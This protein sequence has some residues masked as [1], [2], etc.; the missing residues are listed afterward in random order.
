MKPDIQTPGIKMNQVSFG[1]SSG[2]EQNLGQSNPEAY[3][4]INIERGN[5][6]TEPGNLTNSV[7]PA[8]SLPTPA[9]AD[10]IAVAQAALRDIPIIANDDDLIEKEWVERAKRIVS[11]T[12]GDPCKREGQVTEL[13]VDYL[14]KRFGR[15]L[16]GEQ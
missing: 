3:T 13:K 12:K 14:Q 5:Q 15:K 6:R 7:V 11:D 10:D 1:S 16:G 2:L 4:G 9:G 8:T